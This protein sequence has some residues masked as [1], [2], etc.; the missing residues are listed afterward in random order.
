MH[1]IAYIHSKFI[2]PGVVWV[3]G[4]LRHPF[5]IYCN[6]EHS[7]CLL[8]CDVPATADAIDS[9]STAITRWC[10]ENEVKKVL[11]V[12]GIYPENIH[13]F[14]Q[15]FA[16]R[17]AFVIENDGNLK[18]TIYNNGKVNGNQ[19][20]LFAFIGGLPGQILAN[21]VVRFIHCL[22]VL[23]PTLSFSPDPE[24]AALAIET[25]NNLIPSAKVNTSQLKHEAEIIKTQLSE[26]AKLQYRLLKNNR[27]QDA[28]REDT[29]QIYK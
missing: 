11:V 16:K 17:R 8:T 19:A 10:R 3:G 7:I 14:P 25:I 9:I 13:P 29:E 4:K 23:V 1:Q 5:R 21:C 18:N 15:D 22:A 20:P 6:D 27:T 12:S 24:G 2:M 26:L 28:I